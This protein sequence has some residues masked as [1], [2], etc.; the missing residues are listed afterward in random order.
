M[1]V[2]A[3][4]R[5]YRRPRR[6][7]PRRSPTACAGATRPSSRQ[8][9]AP[10]EGSSPGW[11]RPRATTC[12]DPARCR[13]PRRPSARPAPPARPV[14]ASRRSDGR[15]PADRTGPT[16]SSASAGT[17]RCRRTSP[18]GGCG[19]PIVVHEANA[20]P[21]LANRLGARLTRH[22][23][24]ASPAIRLPHGATSSACRCGGRSRPW[25]A[26]AR[27]AEARARFGL[28]PGPPTLLVTGGSPGRPRLN[29]AVSG[30]AAALAAAGVQVLHAPG[31]GNEDAAAATGRRRAVRRR[32]LPRPDGARLRRRRPGVCRAGAN[33][34]AELAA[35]GLP[36]VYV[37]LPI[38]NGEQRLNA[39]AR[40]RRGRRADGRRRRPDRRWVGDH[41]PS[42][43]GD[44]APAGRDGRSAAALG[45]RDAESGS[46]RWSGVR[47][48]VQ[49]AVE[50]RGDRRAARPGALGRRA[51]P[52]ALRRHRRRR[53]ERDRADPAR[54]RRSGLRQ[55]RQ[56]LQRPG[57]AAGARR[58][59]PCRPRG[60]PRR[61]RRHRRGVHRHPRGEPRARRRTRAPVCGCCPGRRRWRRSWPGGARSPSPAPTARR[62]QPR[63]SPS[64]CSTA[65]PTRRSRSAASS[66]RPGANA[67]DGTRRRLRRRGGRERRLLPRLPTPRSRSS[68]TS[69]PTTWTTTARRRGRHEAFD[70]FTRPCRRGFLVACAD[71]PGARGARRAAPGLAA[72]GCRPT[73][74]PPTPTCAWPRSTWRF[75]RVVRAWWPAAA[76][77][78]RVTLRRARPAQRAQRVGR[79]HRRSRPRVRRQRAASTAWPGSPAPG[80]GSSSRA[81]AGGVPGVRRLRPSP[82]RGARPSSP[83]PGAVAGDGRVVAVFQPH[84]LQPHPHLRVG[85]RE[86]ARR[87]PTR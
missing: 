73:A 48:P 15:G 16:S 37:P 76:A 43:A 74:S 58:H 50:V 40:G 84:L 22:V 11:C 7:R 86:G 25:T 54:P 19:V 9:S 57:G 24:V 6:A 14:C 79:L 80:A 17:S 87:S 31:R 26:Q 28:G 56:G 46:R 77:S 12:A 83:R 3:R 60:R 42:A 41:V 27:Q 38:G 75:R 53:H 5:R 44:P 45:R 36:A 82:D 59:R 81:I 61:R 20:R 52:G 13:C 55:R 34:C 65:A 35:V 1:R 32:A 63:C 85:V 8:R 21:G 67:H 29:D 18:P 33:T 62:R 68:P 30:A 66:T 78:G 10:R 49:A 47:R 4:R 72:S 39:T 70:A 64:R 2:G 23:A 71:D 69:S 51:G